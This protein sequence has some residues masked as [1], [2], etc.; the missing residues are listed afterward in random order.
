MA[1]RVDVC[2][3]MSLCLSLI[4]ARPFMSTINGFLCLL[5]AS[6]AACLFIDPY[7]VKEVR[8]PPGAAHSP[9]PR[10][11]PHIDQPSHIAPPLGRVPPTLNLLTAIPSDFF[12]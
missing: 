2:L 12:T 8:P 1:M 11:L 7:N 6:R 10:R 9:D 3:C 5:G 4:S